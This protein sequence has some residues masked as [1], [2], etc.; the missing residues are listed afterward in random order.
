M[1][2]EAQFLAKRLG[3]RALG[4]GRNIL[5][6]ISF[7]GDSLGT[8]GIIPRSAMARR[9]RST[10]ITRYRPGSMPSCASAEALS[11]PGNPPAITACYSLTRPYRA[12]PRLV[13]R[14]VRN[15]VRTR[16]PSL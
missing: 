16:A 9:I 3:L 7:R 8:A 6:D 1:H 15:P 12:L 11:A 2:G 14:G 13:P 4:D 10:L 5:W